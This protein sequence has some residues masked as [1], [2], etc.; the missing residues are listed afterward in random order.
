MRRFQPCSP[1]GWAQ[2]TKTT[3]C[4]WR[5]EKIVR[6]TVYIPQPPKSRL[7]GTA[8]PTFTDDKDDIIP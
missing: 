1:V 2:P 8:H 6:I 5:G 3:A 7:V 4:G